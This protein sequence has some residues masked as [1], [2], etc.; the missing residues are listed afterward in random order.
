ML[1]ATRN[2]DVDAS[3]LH[4]K[5]TA[6]AAD[7]GGWVSYAWRNAADE[8]L[9][10]KGAYVISLNKWGR[11]FYAGVGYSLLPPSGSG[12]SLASLVA[13]TASRPASGAGTSPLSDSASVRTPAP[14][15]KRGI[16]GDGGRLLNARNQHAFDNL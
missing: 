15:T 6:A 14:G 2:D 13:G 7:G 3:D 12:S 16:G 1:R 5:F 4:A 10:T 8:V 9:R 11:A